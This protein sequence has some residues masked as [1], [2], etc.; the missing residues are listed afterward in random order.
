MA[1]VIAAA[2]S[3]SRLPKMRAS[4]MRFHEKFVLM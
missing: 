4:W 1:V 3:A 2:K